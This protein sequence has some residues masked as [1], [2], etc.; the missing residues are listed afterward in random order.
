MGSPAKNIT[1]TVQYNYVRIR[2]WKK[3]RAKI[4]H[5]FNI[6]SFILHVHKTEWSRIAIPDVYTA[7]RTFILCSET[8][9]AWTKWD[10]NRR[11]WAR[12]CY[13]RRWEINCTVFNSCTTLQYIKIKSLDS[14]FIVHAQFWMKN[15]FLP[16][17]P[18]LLPT[19]PTHPPLKG[20]N[21]EIVMHHLTVNNMQC[22][23]FGQPTKRLQAV[24]MNYC[25]EWQK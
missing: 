18:F 2:I 8:E 1:G 25:S 5:S 3:Q 23:Q 17:P 9:R 24:L 10:S 15:R 19:H 22:G 7:C 4:K 21:W 11:Y 12:N 20:I 16:P 6:L 13:R 14:S